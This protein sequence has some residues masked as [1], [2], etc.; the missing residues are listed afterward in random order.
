MVFAAVVLGVAAAPVPAGA[1]P[2]STVPARPTAMTA[3]AGQAPVAIGALLARSD[4]RLV[5][6]STESPAGRPLAA[7]TDGSVADRGPLRF[8]PA[9]PL[10]SRH[11]YRDGGQ[12]TTLSDG[13][14]MWVFS[15][16]VLDHA[17]ALAVRNSAAL[18]TPD[19][20]DVVVDP[21]PGGKL[22]PLVTPPTDDPDIPNPI[23]GAANVPDCPAT[24][25][26]VGFNSQAAWPSG[27]VARPNGDGTDTVLVYYLNICIYLNATDFAYES[28]SMGVANVSYDPDAYTNLTSPAALPGFAATITDNTLFAAP[29]LFG[30][31]PILA[32]GHVHVY[33]CTGN[34]FGAACRIARAPLANATQTA[35]YTYWDGGAWGTDVVTAAPL[36]FGIGG[37]PFG[38]MQ[39]AELPQAA[40]ALTAGASGSTAA[41]VMTYMLVPDQ[42][43]SVRTAPSP[44]GP[45]SSARTFALG[46]CGT[47]FATGCYVAVPHPSLTTS[48]DLGISFVTQVGR[49]MHV[50]TIP[51]PQADEYT[52]LVA[53]SRIFD[54]RDNTGREPPPPVPSP[55]AAG[56]AVRIDIGGSVIG[57]DTIPAS[58]SGVIVNLTVV[59]RGGGT[60]LVVGPAAGPSS[61]GSTANTPAGA[62]RANTTMVELDSAGSF[63]I[64]NGPGVADVIVDVLG[65]IG[66][67]GSSLLVPRNDPVRILDSRDGTGLAGPAPFG[68]GV[69]VERLASGQVLSGVA[70]PSSVT[71][72]LVNI[73]AVDATVAT[74][75]TAYPAGPKPPTSTVN[76]GA[77]QT[78]AN[79]AVVTLSTNG[80]YA[81][82]NNSGSVHVVVD[83]LGWFEP[84]GGASLGSSFALQS[85][86]RAVDTRDGTGTGAGGHPGPAAKVGAGQVLEVA[87]WLVSGAPAAVVGLVLMVTA[88]RPSSATHLTVVAGG[89]PLPATSTV[90]L[91]AGETV[92]NVVVVPAGA[93][94]AVRNNGGA[95]DVIIDLVGW[96][97]PASP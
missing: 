74:H 80:G 24:K 91:P 30:A 81:V 10:A 67:S 34:L 86:A 33:R 57:A 23:G 94:I 90:N 37:V 5:P 29:H 42:K 1:G 49:A 45:W 21:L 25:D 12:T 36:D 46:P 15:D 70:I 14:T 56:A 54:T 63:T 84:A 20:P 31:S 6:R 97:V 26:G 61:N 27:L 64:T 47:T 55:L 51:L 68:P 65:W 92:A 18:S 4:G 75:L 79:V 9:S 48:T 11:V 8:P 40:A 85:P 78:R 52:P 77:Q 59:S 53:P 69:E 22:V 7:A 88:D 83:L 95:V 3:E 50:G 39:V 58:A 96:L 44:V 60:H 17:N 19:Q 66:P 41:Y 93:T 72:L 13:R 43:V 38:G 71:A 89:R 35:A 2:S 82:F 16:T 32:D 73:T 87:G 76:V 62:T 28:L